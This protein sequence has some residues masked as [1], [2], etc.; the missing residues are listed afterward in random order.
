M[1]IVEVLFKCE[2]CSKKNNI[3]DINGTCGKC[4]NNRLENF[5]IITTREKLRGMSGT[6]TLS[7][8]KEILKSAL[9]KEK[10]C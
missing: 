8:A 4:D 7:T 5:K 9:N 2:K 3:S 1:F 10:I 6:Q